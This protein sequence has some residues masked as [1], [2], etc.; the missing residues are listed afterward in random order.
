[1]TIITKLNAD[2]NL[3]SFNSHTTLD[4]EFVLV[5]QLHYAQQGQYLTNI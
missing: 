3:T 5:A 2:G 1:M 4:K